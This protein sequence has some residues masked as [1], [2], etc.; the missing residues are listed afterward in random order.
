MEGL[1]LQVPEKKN[2]AI[3]LTKADFYKAKLFHEVGSFYTQPIPSPFSFVYDTVNYSGAKKMG[4]FYIE[5]SASKAELIRLHF[6]IMYQAS[7]FV[8]PHHVT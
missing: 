3:H 7:G 2:Y 8:L 6:F 4:L 1:G 5:L